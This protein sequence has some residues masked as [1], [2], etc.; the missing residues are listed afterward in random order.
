M[1]S[2][3]IGL[4]GIPNRA[5]LSWLVERFVATGE[6]LN[7]L[8]LGVGVLTSPKMLNGVP[9]RNAASW[10]SKEAI[11]DI[12]ITLPFVFNIL[13]FVDHGPLTDLQALEEASLAAGDALDALQLDMVWP[14]PVIVR[15]FADANDHLRVILSLGT[16]AR[17]RI[18]DDA[19]TLI[20]RLKPYEDALSDVVL[21]QSG[22]PASAMNAALLEPLIYEI[23]ARRPDLGVT[24][25]GALDKGMLRAIEPLIRKFPGLSID[26][27]AAFATDAP[28]RE[29]DDSLGLSDH[30]VRAAELFRH[31]T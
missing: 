16:E 24:I 12:I 1:T 31:C 29:D 30:L 28:G 8:Q 3:Y 18:D 10:P 25:A 11:A 21:D 6:H 9:S 20:E 2:R 7:G 13:H 14:D 19:E 5:W 23:R 27:G 4:N 22:N 15:E 26:A 17:A